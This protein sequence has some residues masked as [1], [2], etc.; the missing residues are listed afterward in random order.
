MK[1]FAPPNG[2]F[3][4]YLPIEWQYM[5]IAAGYEEK[6]PYS[7]Q[8]YE[9]NVGAFQISCYPTEGKTPPEDRIIHKA[10]DPVYEFIETKIEDKIFEVHLWFSSVEDHFFMA[11]YIYDKKEINNPKIKDEIQDL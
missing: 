3:I 10:E 1:Y 11:K 4:L 7:F 5:N 6:P 2:D 9:K 8:L